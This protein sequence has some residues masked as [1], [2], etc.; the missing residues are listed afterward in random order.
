[1]E[2][3]SAIK[4]R[5]LAIY[6]NV[7]GTRGYYAKPNKSI[8]EGQLLYDFTHMWKLRNNMEDHR[9]KEIK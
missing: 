2:Y 1:M 4:K 5:N 3:Y 8:R 6:N 7:D 9:G